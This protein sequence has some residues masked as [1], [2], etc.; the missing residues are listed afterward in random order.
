MKLTINE[1][2]E[3]L[4]VSGITREI[5][6]RLIKEYVEIKRSYYLGKY[7]EVI[8]HGGKFS[9]LILALIESKLSREIVNLDKIGFNE[10]YNRIKSYPKTTAKEEILTLAIPRVARSVY[11]LRSKKDVVHVKTVDPDSI[12]AYYCVA[13]CDWMLSEIALLLLELNEEE[14]YNILKSA[15]EKKIPIIE[16]FE[17]G[18]A[19]ILRKDF[20]I[21]DQILLFLYNEYPERLPIKYLKNNVKTR[22]VYT[23][24]NSLEREK[25]I[26]RSKDGVKLTQLGI[27]YVEEKLLKRSD[28]L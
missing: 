27:K 14:V 17:N 15:L 19:M 9:E 12:D 4:I 6:E 20:S 11:T 8:K 18:T 7:E 24:L 28:L 16:K 26:H 2:I 13:A 21:S 23:Y 25:L 3:K 10:L 22:N 5:S 1:F